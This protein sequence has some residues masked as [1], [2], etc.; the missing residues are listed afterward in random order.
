LQIYRFF[1]KFVAMDKNIVSEVRIKAIEKGVNLTKLC[2]LAGINRC[3]LT[4]WE[5]REPKSLATLKKLERTL[6]QL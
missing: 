4:H 2:A 6:D 1:C 5:K 3:V